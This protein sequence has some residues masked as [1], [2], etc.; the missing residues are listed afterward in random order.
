MSQ[1][2]ISTL[3]ARRDAKLRELAGIGPFIGG[4]LAAVKV[5]IVRL[6]VKKLFPWFNREL[7]K[8]PDPR[9]GEDYL[10]QVGDRPCPV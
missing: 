10:M 8:I 3:K 1:E 6:P 9:R 4:S 7:D 5:R 2:S